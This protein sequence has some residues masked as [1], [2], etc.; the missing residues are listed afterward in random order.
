VTGHIFRDWSA[1]AAGFAV[2]ASPA[3]TL[4]N[5]AGHPVPGQVGLQNSVTPIMDS[6]TAFHDGV[7]MWTITIIMIVVLGL[8]L[9]IIY[10][11]NAK[12]NPVP[13]TNHHNTLLEIAWTVIPIIILI[14]IA[15]PSFGVL[16]DQLTMPDGQ[17][18]YLGS[19]IFSFGSVDVPAP[20][21]TIK[22]TGNTWYW[23]YTYVDVG[24][25]FDSNILDE[26]T[27]LAE[28][29][30]Q[31]RLLAVDNFMIVPLKA[32]VRLQ[33]TGDP[34]GV[35]HAFAVPSFGIIMDAVPGR[36]NETWFNAEKTGTY[37]GQCRELC[38][39]DHAFMPIGVKVVE[40]AQY[41]VWL[42]ALKDGGILKA[43]ATLAAAN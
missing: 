37:Y 41:D 9:Y 26:T 38:G 32:T 2:V 22:V 35:I 24:K 21:V 10:R 36:L 7:L 13:S 40:Q 8:L 27:R 23:N 25:N 29:S 5:E 14:V 42:A 43:N 3:L 18:K 28:T 34:D 31:P 1:R 11:F 12:R 6:I 19:N 39:K 17:R 15:I 4:A 33:I 20:S 30:P 16:S